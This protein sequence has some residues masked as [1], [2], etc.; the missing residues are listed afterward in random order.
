MCALSFA[1]A[2]AGVVE[3]FTGVDALIAVA[4]LAALFFLT[5]TVYLLE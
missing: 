3:T 1:A 5:A 2:G 4:F